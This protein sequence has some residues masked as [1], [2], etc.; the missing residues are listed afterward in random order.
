MLLAEQID[1]MPSWDARQFHK[2]ATNMV[3][4]VALR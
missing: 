3:E 1:H 2:V 4:G